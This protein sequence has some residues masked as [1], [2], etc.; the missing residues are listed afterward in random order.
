M[1]RYHRYSYIQSH[2]HHIPIHYHLTYIMYMRLHYKSKHILSLYT[3]HI[4]KHAARH[5]RH[6]Y[7]VQYHDHT[8]TYC[9]T[10]NYWRRFILAKLANLKMRQK[11]VV[12]K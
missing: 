5:Q 7:I 9:N 3:D 6:M 10:I 2:S 11:F 1:Y 8:C 4:I 12:V